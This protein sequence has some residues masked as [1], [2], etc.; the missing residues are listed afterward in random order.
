MF[1]SAGLRKDARQLY[2]DLR[3]GRETRAR[4]QPMDGLEQF[5]DL[6]DA[7]SLI[8]Q[9]TGFDSNLP[10]FER[11]GCAIEVGRP[12]ERGELCD[13]DDNRIIPGL[14]GMGLG[15][16]IVP[17]E[18]A[19]EPSFTGGLHG[20]QSYPLT[21]APGLIDKMTAAMAAEKVS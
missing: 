10:R 2:L 4:M 19:G 15:F 17:G 18:A 11:D 5:R 14:F 3:D 7:S 21:I 20:F 12:S 13:L 16:N 6:L 9:A 8:L 1:R